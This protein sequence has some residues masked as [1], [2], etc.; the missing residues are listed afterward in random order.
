MVFAVDASSVGCTLTAGVVSF[1]SAGSC[2]ISA[3]QA[4]NTTYN[5][6]PEV[7]VATA[8]VGKADLVVTKTV[9][10]QVVLPGQSSVTFTTSV[11][12]NGPHTAELTTVTDVV[13]AG[14][15]VIES[16]VTRGTVALPTWDVGSLGSGQTATMSVTVTVPEL[17]MYTAG[18]DQFGN[19]QPAT[20][21]E[22][23]APVSYRNCASAS[24]SAQDVVPVN[25]SACATVTRSWNGR[26][27]GYWKNKPAAWPTGTSN[28]TLGQVFTSVV[29]ISG[30]RTV[31]Q[32]TTL[33]QAL[34]LKGGSDLDIRAQNV[35]ELSVKLAGFGGSVEAHDPPE[36]RDSLARVG[37]ELVAQYGG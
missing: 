31:K 34:A 17:R 23:R 9:S 4:G 32:T 18:K 16:T 10:S 15:V 27:P 21:G 19:D 25:N 6:A 30:C 13:P 35:R 24:S 22:D 36:L 20:G 5:A 1:V 8:V 7:K 26:T 3:N 37:R 33:A 14:L 2:V 29:G 12:N 11:R 28:L